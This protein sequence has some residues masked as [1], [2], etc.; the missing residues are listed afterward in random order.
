MPCVRDWGRREGRGE[1]DGERGEGEGERGERKGK[2]WNFKGR[3][4]RRKGEE[5]RGKGREGR[6]RW[7]CAWV[8]EPTSYFAA[9]NVVLEIQDGLHSLLH[10]LLFLPLLPL[11]ALGRS[12]LAQSSLQKLP[13]LLVHLLAFLHRRVCSSLLLADVAVSVVG[14]W[15]Y[16]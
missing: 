13:F 6:A 3:K 1:R 7:H 16:V 2:R 4:R 10:V 14:T 8:W 9:C 12:V 5:K 15:G 11:L